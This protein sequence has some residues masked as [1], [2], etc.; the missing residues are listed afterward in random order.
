MYGIFARIV[1]KPGQLQKLMD[2]AAWVVEVCKNQEPGNLRFDFYQDPED[3]NAL[4]M[5]EAYEDMQAFELHKRLEPYIHWNTVLKKEAV[6]Y[7][8]VFFR[9]EALFTTAD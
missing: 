1:A 3:E 8:T 5:Y 6:D 7:Y 4:Y 9:E 2:Q